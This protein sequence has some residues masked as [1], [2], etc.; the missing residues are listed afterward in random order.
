MDMRSKTA[1]KHSTQPKQFMKNQKPAHLPPN[2]QSIQK[3]VEGAAKT[4]QAP[5]RTYLYF[6]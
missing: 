3:P 6:K 5:H 2:S 4:Q 1:P